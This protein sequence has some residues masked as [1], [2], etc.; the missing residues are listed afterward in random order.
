M[1]TNFD[2][3]KLPTNV[4][5]RRSALIKNINDIGAIWSAQI[6]SAKITFSFRD[7][8]TKLKA[9]KAELKKVERLISLLE[10]NVDLFRD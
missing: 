2:F 6:N 1:Y 10:N 4:Y 9:T 3:D 5:E 8:R 7:L